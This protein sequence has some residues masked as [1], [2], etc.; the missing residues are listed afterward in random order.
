MTGSIELNVF[1][2]K[3]HFWTIYW[4]AGWTTCMKL[5]VAGYISIINLRITADLDVRGKIIGVEN[6][7]RG[8][9]DCWGG[10][11]LLSDSDCLVVEILSCCV[12]FSGGAKMVWA[13]CA[14]ELNSLL[15]EVSCLNISLLCCLLLLFRLLVYTFQCFNISNI[16]CVTS[17]ALV[18]CCATLYIISYA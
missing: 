7:P 15:T 1:S 17:S 10:E 12:G 14:E 18:S 11:L 2:D 9:L 8:L 13:I 6:H 5:S 16:S 3:L 4:C